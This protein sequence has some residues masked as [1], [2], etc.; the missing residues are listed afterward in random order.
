MQRKKC[1][2]TLGGLRRKV[3][4]Y[5][6]WGVV[7]T[8]VVAALTLA[9]NAASSQSGGEP[10]SATAGE[11]P[12]LRPGG[13]AGSQPDGEPE[14]A[15]TYN[16]LHL[17]TSAKYPIGNLTFD[18]YGNLYGTTGG[19]GG[20]PKCPGGCG[21]V[22][23]LAP[24][25]KGAW[26]VSILHAFTSA[27]GRYPRAGLVFDAAGS[28]Y[29]TTA[30]G[31]AHGYGVVFKLAPNADGTWTESVL[32][33]FGGLADLADGAQ[34]YAG[35]VFDTAGNLYGTTESGGA[36]SP[37][38]VVFKLTPNA[39]GTWTESVLHSFNGADGLQPEAGLIFDATGNLYGTTLLD[40]V[41]KLAPNSDGTWTES[42]LYRFQNLEFGSEPRA[43]LVIGAAGRLYG[44]TTGGGAGYGVV[45]KLTPNRDGTWTESVLHFFRGPDG[46]YP[47]AGLVFDAAGNLYGTTTGGGAGYGVVF[48]LTPSS[49]GWSETV[50][51]T[52]IGF[53]AS[54]VAPVIF[55]RAGNLYGTTSDGNH[56]FDYGL[57]FEITR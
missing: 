23:K 28:L 38:G 54:P 22:W 20:S 3:L 34:P 11:T 12:A 41:F 18:A 48:K 40:N 19:G 35:L 29:G 42:V 52:F 15:G 26:T 7:V 31:G 57:V 10:D 53:G 24:S 2:A 14:R 49:S 27:D 30:F 6:C 44:T 37:Y 36:Y 9:S 16:I 55:D 13:A 33:S 51:H 8:I 43:G 21:A 5:G 1:F 39:D 32:Y 4:G 17:F 46:A 50:L 25:P 56:A 47:Q 45:F